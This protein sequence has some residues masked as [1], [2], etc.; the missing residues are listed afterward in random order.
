LN[1]ATEYYKDLFG[2]EPCYNFRIDS[3]IW[4]ECEKLNKADNR[5]LC[6]PFSEIEIKNALF[7]MERNKAPRPARMPIKFYPSCWDIVKQDIVH[8]FSDFHDKMVGISRLNYGIITLLP[9]IKD[10][11]KIQQYM[12]ICLLNCLYKLITKVLTLR[13]E[14]YAARLIHDTNCVHE[15]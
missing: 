6:Q 9:K 4:D 1:H 2:P 8:L 5:I 12:P 13:I 15:R 3:S 10:A 11:T 7:M 14:P